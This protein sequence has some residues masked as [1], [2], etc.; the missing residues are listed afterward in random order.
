MKP[1]VLKWNKNKCNSFFGEKNY[2]AKKKLYKNFVLFQWFSNKE[3]QIWMKIFIKVE[4]VQEKLLKSHVRCSLWK[5][6]FKYKYLTHKLNALNLMT[7]ILIMFYKYKIRT[8]PYI[9]FVA[10]TI[11]QRTKQIFC[12]M[13]ICKVNLH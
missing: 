8:I 2:K 5:A 10:W 4:L 12:C 9:Y 11:D 6:Q 3:K 7:W 1:M 13:F